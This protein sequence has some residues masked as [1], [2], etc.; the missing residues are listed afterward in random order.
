ML[1]RLLAAIEQA[2]R[3]GRPLARIHIHRDDC[4]DLERELFT[5]ANAG[6]YDTIDLPEGAYL[7]LAGVPVH[8]TPLDGGSV[9]ARGRPW[10]SY[11]D[12][13]GFVAPE[14]WTRTVVVGKRCFLPDDSPQQRQAAAE[15]LVEAAGIKPNA[16]H[17]S[18]SI[19][20]DR[21]RIEIDSNEQDSVRRARNERVL[22]ELVG[23]R[24][25]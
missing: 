7:R 10:C 22:A 15:R 12:G 13:G 18:I 20:G 25:G 4:A 6:H 21:I 1:K 8:P 3:E 17:T 24:H 23:A 5:G 14:I 19:V 2:K 9:I 16:V 11:A